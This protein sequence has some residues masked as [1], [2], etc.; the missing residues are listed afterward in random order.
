MMPSSPNMDS[1]KQEQMFNEIWNSCDIKNQGFIFA[2]ELTNLFEFNKDK[3]IR[4]LSTHESNL[5]QQFS[6]QDPTYKITKNDVNNVLKKLVNF[7]IF[8]MLKPTTSVGPPI[9]NGKEPI[10]K[11]DANTKDKQNIIVSPSNTSNNNSPKKKKNPNLIAEIN[12]LTRQLGIKDNIISEKQLLI[13]DLKENVETYKRKFQFLQK[14]FLF[15]KENVG[16][17]YSSNYSQYSLSEHDGIKDPKQDFLLSEF[18]R[19]IQEQKSI[20]QRLQERIE[21]KK[22]FNIPTNI[23]NSIISNNERKKHS[24]IISSLS[25]FLFP[26]LLPILT[27]SL[28]VIFLVIFYLFNSKDNASIEWELSWWERS[29]W[30]S[31][32]GWSLKDMLSIFTFTPDNASN[33]NIM[34]DKEAFDA[35]MRALNNS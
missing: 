34:N 10:G 22:P 32:L 18:K 5:I 24:G 28:S 3:F 29:N 31:S 27:F 17:K 33:N 1:S 8:Q 14:E 12:N 25:N 11:N 16:K 23:D 9:E 2:D 13:D 6:S 15:Y 21:L 30:L 35:Y 19:Q 7:T 26:Y 20:I 4:P